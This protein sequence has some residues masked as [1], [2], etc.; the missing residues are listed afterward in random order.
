MKPTPAQ[1]AALR[2]AATEAIRY[3]R[4]GWYSVPSEVGEDQVSHSIAA[5]GSKSIP[6]RTLHALIENGLVASPR[7]SNLYDRR[8]TLTDAGRAVLDSMNAKSPA[9]SDGDGA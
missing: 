8:W 7:T 2:L 6:E 5:L 9:S 4:G 3:Y 1:L